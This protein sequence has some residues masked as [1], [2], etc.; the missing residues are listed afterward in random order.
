MSESLNLSN[1]TCDRKIK[2]SSKK[3]ALKAR[4]SMIKIHGDSARKLQHY[5]CPYC[6]QYHLGKPSK[7]KLMHQKRIKKEN[8][9]LFILALE[10]AL[11]RNQ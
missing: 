2:Y 1:K 8:E 4:K 10:R 9:A 7:D 6:T 3:L 11:I 5:K